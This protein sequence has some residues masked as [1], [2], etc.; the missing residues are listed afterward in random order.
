MNT[1]EKIHKTIIRLIII[2]EQCAARRGNLKTHQWW[3]LNLDRIIKRKN[4]MNNMSNLWI[5]TYVLL[6]QSKL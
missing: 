2:Y 5:C 4:K 1:E 6:M 3:K